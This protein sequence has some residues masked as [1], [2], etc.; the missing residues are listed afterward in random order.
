MQEKV[1]AKWEEHEDANKVNYS[2]VPIVILGSKFD[3]FANQ[4]ESR[5]KKTLCMAMR[6]IAHVNT[7]DL[8][9]GSVKEKLPSQLY[10]AVL[11]SHAFDSQVGHIDMNHNNPINCPSG[12]DS[13][14][15]IDEP[16]GAQQR[17]KASLD[18]LWQDVCE[19]DFEKIPEQSAQASKL[20]AGMAKYPEEKVDQMRRQKDEEL[21]HYVKQTQRA[22]RFES[23]Q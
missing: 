9:F 8:V 2:M 11:N 5:S 14:S 13:L 17:S 10:R 21:E 1:K 18:S 19:R 23:K 20:L 6:Y 22:K 3:Q 16:D 7:C 4:Y 12:K 15:K